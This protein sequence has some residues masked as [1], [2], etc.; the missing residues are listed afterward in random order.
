VDQT[1]AAARYENGVLELS[2]PKAQQS[3][4]KLLEI[5]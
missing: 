1:K 2:L 3:E 4:S 5:A